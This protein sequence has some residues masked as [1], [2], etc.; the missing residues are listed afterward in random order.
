MQT[1]IELLLQLRELTEAMEDAE[2]ALQDMPESEE[3]DAAIADLDASMAKL[4]A[5]YSVDMPEKLAALLAY[6]DECKALAE[7]ATQQMHN[8]KAVVE[9]RKRR[10]ERCR[11]MALHLVLANGGP[12]SL[13]GGRRA[14]A[15]ER[16]TYSVSVEDPSTLPPG[17][18]KAKYSADKVKL[19]EALQAGQTI[20]GCALVEST[21]RRVTVADK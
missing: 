20:A 9:R 15:S 1:T 7:S 17:F 16:T 3:R 8:W 14:K 18:R 11:E 10:I 2:V 5:W 13:P 6:V 12:V 19:R 21:A 4:E